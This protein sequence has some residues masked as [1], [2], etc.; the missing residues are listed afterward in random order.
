MSFAGI[1]ILIVDDHPIFRLGLA[2]VLASRG[3]TAITV[4]DGS[5]TDPNALTP[6][7]LECGPWVALLDVRLGAIDGVQIC[8]R[9]RSSP[10]P[11]L[12]IMLTTYEEPAVV[13]A[14]KEAGAFAFLSKEADVEEI[15]A[16][17]ELGLRGA[18]PRIPDQDIPVLTTRER[19]VLGLLHEGLDNKSMAQRLGIGTATVKDHLDNLYGK[20]GV[21]DRLGAVRAAS[22]LGLVDLL[23]S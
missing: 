15:V 8:K 23:G 20:L 18:D 16:A 14:A 13:Q 4:S 10:R 1:P 9:L 6:G 7:G 12:V 5:V 21:S 2:T 3:F 11:P 17:I 22:A 19:E